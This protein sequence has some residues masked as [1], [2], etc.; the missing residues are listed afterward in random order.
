MPIHVPSVAFGLL[1]C[2]F[3]GAILLGDVRTAWFNRK[4]HSWPTTTAAVTGRDV[5][6]R[7]RGTSDRRSY[8]YNPV[9]E[10]EYTENGETYTG[11][12]F[13]YPI[14]SYSFGSSEEARELAE[15]YETGSLV[16][17]HVDP[18]RPSRSVLKT[19]GK[20]LGHLPLVGTII[21]LGFFAFGALWTVGFVLIGVGVVG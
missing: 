21:G 1:L 2:L 14:D 19:D 5:Q 11:D 17:V 12:R 8:S 15:E 3:S 7:A 10:Y 20:M 18:N 16:T 4:S 13:A 9:V 6:Q